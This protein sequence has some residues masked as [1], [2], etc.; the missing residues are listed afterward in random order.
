MS[1]LLMKN[2]ILKENNMATTNG[3]NF[4]PNGVFKTRIRMAKIRNEKF[5]G[6]SKRFAYVNKQVDSW[7]IFIIGGYRLKDG[8]YYTL[9]EA[10]DKLNQLKKYNCRLE[11][12]KLNPATI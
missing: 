4:R 5:Y 6:E 7:G 1:N 9:K 3:R 2:S 11:I 12:R 8:P 10:E